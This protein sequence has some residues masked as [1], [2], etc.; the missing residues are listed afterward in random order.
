MPIPESLT[1]KTTSRPSRAAL[2][3][4]FAARFGVLGRVHHQVRENLFQA[5]RIGFDVDVF[6][7]GR[8]MERVIA[9]GKQRSGGFRDTGHNLADR[10]SR[11][12]QLDATAGD[13]GDVQQVVDQS[14]H[15]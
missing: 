6:L 9:R 1:R 3:Q 13:A 4:T 5:E 8:E 12:L 10:N 2:N 15:Q 11:F 7:G 14:L